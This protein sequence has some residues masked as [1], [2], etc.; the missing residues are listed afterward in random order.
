MDRRVEKSMDKIRKQKYI[1]NE[2][3]LN[4]TCMISKTIGAAN[5]HKVTLI[6]NLIL[7]VFQ[8]E[9]FVCGTVIYT[10]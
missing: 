2:S 6:W 9:I 8:N 7:G 5:I 1:T 3:S 10:K 4:L